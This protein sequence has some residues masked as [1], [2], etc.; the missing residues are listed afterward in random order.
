M[1][2]CW[3]TSC[4]QK[5]EIETLHVTSIYVPGS[6]WMQIRAYNYLASNHMC[7][8]RISISTDKEF[9]CNI[10]LESTIIGSKG[11]ST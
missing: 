3:Q 5:F 10:R 8:S 7:D 6:V 4:Q 1:Q 11:Q 2:F 9:G